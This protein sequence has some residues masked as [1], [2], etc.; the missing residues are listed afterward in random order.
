MDWL[1][2]TAYGT[3]DSYLYVSRIV[4]SSPTTPF[5]LGEIMEP[6][7]KKEPFISMKLDGSLLDRLVEAGIPLTRALQYFRDNPEGPASETTKLVAEE[8]VPFYY[9]YRN[10]GDWSDYAKEAVLIGTP[11]K[12][13][14]GKYRINKQRTNAVNEALRKNAETILFPGLADY[15]RDLATERPI[16][17]EEMTELNAYRPDPLINDWK[18]VIVAEGGPEYTT[19]FRDYIEPYS[20]GY[21]LGNPK[22][23]FPT[24]YE[25]RQ[26]MDRYSSKNM[27]NTLKRRNFTNYKFTVGEYYDAI[28]NPDPVKLYRMDFDRPYSYYGPYES[29]VRGMRGLNQ[30]QRQSLLDLNREFEQVLL[31]QTLDETTKQTKL[32]ALKQEIDLLEILGE[33]E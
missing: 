18:D 12:G 33:I 7:N 6:Y 11:I 26:L 23:Q 25:P 19:N 15:R 28:N 32:N 10:D 3:V 24:E 22:K 31:D 4:G 30:E 13:K 17:F 9:N 27:G 16:R 14:T 21:W 29:K 1:I 5:S 2:L 8:T 20:N